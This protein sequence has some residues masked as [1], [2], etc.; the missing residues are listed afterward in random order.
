VRD[1]GSDLGSRPV[2]D[3]AGRSRSRSGGD[4]SDSASSRKHGE[5]LTH[6]PSIGRDSAGHY[7]LWVVLPQI[8]PEPD[9][10]E[11]NAILAAL[12]ADEAERPAVSEW[13]AALLP[14]REDEEP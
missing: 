9:E 8:T 7:P 1:D 4:H 5:T 10:A 6:V 2:R 12:A 13:S 11:R 3:L 14:D